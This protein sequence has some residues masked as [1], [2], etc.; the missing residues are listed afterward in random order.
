[1]AKDFVGV[2]FHCRDHQMI[3]YN[4]DLGDV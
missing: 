4:E 1:M 2:N 3:M